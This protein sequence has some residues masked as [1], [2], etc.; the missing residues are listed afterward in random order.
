[1]YPL[2]VYLTG[3]PFDSTSLLSALLGGRGARIPNV[4]LSTMAFY[5]TALDFSPNDKQTFSPAEH[6]PRFITL[7]AVLTD[8]PPKPLT[9]MSPFLIQIG[10]QGI[11]GTPTSVKE[12][13]SG[14]LLIEVTKNE[15]STS[16]QDLN[17]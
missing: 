8:S 5:Q 15:P 6:W 9:K 14:A 2:G 16:L 17:I 12:L 3:S 1:M 7:E 10:I 4:N 13:R 11:V